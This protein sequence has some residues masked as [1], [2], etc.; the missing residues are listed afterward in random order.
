M[1]LQVQVE[2][3]KIIPHNLEEAFTSDV[4]FRYGTACIGTLIDRPWSDDLW[5]DLT[6]W[7]MEV[8]SIHEFGDM[9]KWW[10][11]LSEEEQGEFQL[12]VD[13]MYWTDFTLDVL[14]VINRH[15]LFMYDSREGVYLNTPISGVW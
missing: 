15:H 7:C 13:E 5:E 8:A 2:N 10:S 3:F 1:N 9:E 6:E 14:L 11:G 12:T 4:L